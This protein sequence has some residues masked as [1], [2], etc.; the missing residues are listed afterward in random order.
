MLCPRCNK[1]MKNIKHFEK[2][3]RYQYNECTICHEKTKNKRIHYEDI[4]PKDT[5]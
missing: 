3:K 1:N 2:D 4:F 5:K